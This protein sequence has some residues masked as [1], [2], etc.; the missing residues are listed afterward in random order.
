MNNDNS[1]HTDEGTCAQFA[2]KLLSFAAKAETFMS[3]DAIWYAFIG[4]AIAYAKHHHIPEA[5]ICDHLH[6]VAD[7]FQASEPP[8]PM[9]N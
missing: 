8:A 2:D 3:P 7:S 9:V 5:N 6:G 1:D 4:A